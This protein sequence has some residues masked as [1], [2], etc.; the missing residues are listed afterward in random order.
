MMILAGSRQEER[1]GNFCS[2]PSRLYMK[3]Q[4]SDQLAS[5]CRPGATEATYAKSLFNSFTR[6][7]RWRGSVRERWPG[8]LGGVSAGCHGVPLPGRPFRRAA[9]CIGHFSLLSTSA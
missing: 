8:F 2:Q 9:P 1:A 6:A 5:G 4:N 7:I 3:Q